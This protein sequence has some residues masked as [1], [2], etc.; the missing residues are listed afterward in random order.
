M[1]VSEGMYVF[2]SAVLR[3]KSR[4]V[5]SSSILASCALLVVSL[6]LL[7]AP[8]Q[9]RIRR[10]LSRVVTD[11][12]A[13]YCVALHADTAVSLLIGVMLLG[14][15]TTTPLYVFSFFFF[16]LPLLPCVTD[17]GND[18]ES[19]TQRLHAGNPW[20]EAVHRAAHRSRRSH[21]A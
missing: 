8:L 20:Q 9:V 5:T 6:A 2:S 17:G 11:A 18:A 19:G 13:A 12:C 15:T 4:T 1:D 21:E 3:L 10:T 16:Q 14:A 7:R